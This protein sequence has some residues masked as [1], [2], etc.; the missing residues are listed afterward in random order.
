MAGVDE[1]VEHEIDDSIFAA[2]MHGGLGAILSEWLKPG[3]LSARKDH[4][5]EVFH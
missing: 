2:E 1:V 5:E 4:G 3:A